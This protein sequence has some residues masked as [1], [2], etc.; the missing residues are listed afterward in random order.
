MG[1]TTAAAC[2]AL[3]AVMLP[4]FLVGAL[5][6]HL[7]RD[8]GIGEAGLG[9]VVTALFLVAAV[10]APVAG[11]LAERTGPALPLRTGV[12][13]AAALAAIAATARGPWYLGVALAAVGVTI[14]LVDTG[15]ARAF[16]DQIAGDRLGT[17]FG[18]KEASV[19]AASL[20]AGL[21]VPTLAAGVGWR[22]AFLAAAVVGIAVVAVVPRNPPRQSGGAAGP[23]AAGDAPTAGATSG[24]ILVFAAGVGL[25]AGAATATATFLVPAMLNRGL[26]ATAAGLSLSAASI[27]SILA[28]LLF[29]RW[30]DRPSAAPVEAIA[31]MC[32]VGAAAS[33]VLIAPVPAAVAVA[34]AIVVVGAGWGW[35]GLAFLA[36]VR[37]NPAAPGAAAGT[38]LSGLGAGGALG[39]LAYGALAGRVGYAAAWAAVALAFLAAGATSVMARR[40]FA[41]P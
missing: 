11:R 4:V 40:R 19:P 5:G 20:L 6:D 18:I 12:V 21:A 31:V 13:G 35:T 32:L 15:A 1:R 41:R 9:A 28:R 25:G 26:G 34:A 38:V 24:A 7:R 29:G 33:V 16:A 2:A 22:S 37:A 30:A 23:A 8:L 10:A 17:A 14:A 27:A 36:A 3:T 39:P